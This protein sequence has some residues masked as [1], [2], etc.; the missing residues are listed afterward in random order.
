MAEETELDVAH[1]AMEASPEDDALRLAFHERLVE[2]E[3]YLALEREALGEE[4][5]PRVFEVEGQHFVLVFDR[6]ERLA[7]FAGGAAPYAALPGRELARMLAGQGIGLAV[8]LEV[9]SSATLLPAESVDWIAETLAEGPQEEEARISEVFP[10]HALPQALVTGLDRK[11][12]R[13]SG[14]AR[15]AYLAGVVYET[16]AQGHVLAFVG[17][18]DGAERVLAAAV[19]EALTFSGVEAGSLDVLFLPPTAPLA[20]ALARHGLR[21]DLPQPEQPGEQSP[22]GMDPEKPPRL[23]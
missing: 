21:F 7:Q 15:M 16:G 5:E 9:A 23:H 10:P 11:L 6:A 19:S 3:L 18:E 20:A 1:A 14:L 4:I 2:G 13:A 12:A 22:P 17:A 8:N